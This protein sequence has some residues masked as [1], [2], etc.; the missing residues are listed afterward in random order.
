MLEKCQFTLERRTILISSMPAS[1]ISI[2]ANFAKKEF[3]IQI[4]DPFVINASNRRN[5]HPKRT[6]LVKMQK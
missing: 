1:I 5:P 4:K 3:K 2:N 6:I